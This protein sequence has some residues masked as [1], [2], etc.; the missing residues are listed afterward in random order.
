MPFIQILRPY[1]WS[2]N[3]I[4]FVAIL[5]SPTQIAK[6]PAAWSK[7]MQAF[8][9]FC[10]M[11]SAVYILNDI[12]DLKNDPKENENLAAVNNGKVEEMKELL[13]KSLLS[14]P[15]RPYGELVK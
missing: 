10:L 15:G 7:I 3:L 4:L 11:S 2:K 14:F 1:Q 9:A 6:D 8:A 5:F 12:F 13:V